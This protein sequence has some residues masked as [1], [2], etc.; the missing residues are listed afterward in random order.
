MRKAVAAGSN[1]AFARV[2]TALT[3]EPGVTVGGQKGFGSG[4]LKVNGKIFAMVSSK[5]QFVVKLPKVRV[6]EMVSGGKGE[7]FDP[8]R[9]RIM[10]Q[11][12]VVTEGPAA[13]S[14]LAREA[15]AFVMAGR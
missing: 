13:W 5:G 12:L 4:A 11:W 14:A 6:D 9:G 7:R 8:G 2:V 1:S 3:A 15:R 10:K